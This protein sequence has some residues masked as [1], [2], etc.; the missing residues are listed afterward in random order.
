MPAILENPKPIWDIGIP[1]NVRKQKM[2]LAY[3]NRYIDLLTRFFDSLPAVDCSGIPAPHIPT[4][5][6]LY[7]KAKYKIAFFGME[8]KGW[9][10]LE[11]LRTELN[12]DPEKAFDYLT[13][14]FRELEFVNWTNNFG[15][16]FWNFILLFLSRFYNIRDWKD[17]RTDETVQYI[18]RTFMWGNTNSIERFG[19]TAGPNG[20]LR[21]TWEIVKE[22]SRLLDSAEHILET[23]PPDILLV[24]NWSESDKWLAGSR[25]C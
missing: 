1:A 6:E 25:V 3:K 23:C 10:D 4:V 12:R 16:S 24:L 21:K 11:D 2:N 15:T 19:I 5:G 9:G 13:E 14:D 18:L 17:L 8:T 20:V 22:K 7:E